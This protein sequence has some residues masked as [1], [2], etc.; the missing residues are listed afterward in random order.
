[1]RYVFK[2]KYHVKTTKSGSGFVFNL[3][4]PNGQ[5]IANPKFIT[6]WNL[7]KRALAASASML[8]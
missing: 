8:R 4:A 2:G 7:A 1:V 6:L 5:V 3:K